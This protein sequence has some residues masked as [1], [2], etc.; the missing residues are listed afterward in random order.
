MQQHCRCLVFVAVNCSSKLAV[1]RGQVIRLTIATSV[2]GTNIETHNNGL[3]G[4]DEI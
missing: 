1:M 2:V 3:L 4:E